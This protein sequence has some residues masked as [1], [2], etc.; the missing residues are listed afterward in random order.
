[1]MILQD[2]KPT[3]VYCHDGVIYSRLK[4]TNLPKLER[5]QYPQRLWYND[6]YDGP[7]SGVCRLNN[8]TYKFECVDELENYDEYDDDEESEE[9]GRV[10]VLVKLS[11]KE[12]KTLTRRHNMYRLSRR[13]EGEMLGKVF[14]NSLLK[15]LRRKFK[16]DTGKWY[17]KYMDLFESKKMNFKNNQVIAWYCEPGFDYEKALMRNLL[18]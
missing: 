11:K 1:M 4:S 5:S 8:E 7:L 13:Y 6:Y 12:I 18:V 2:I 9:R 17:G 14:G 10:F 16:L 15:L 3:R